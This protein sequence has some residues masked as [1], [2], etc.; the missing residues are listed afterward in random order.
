MNKLRKLYFVLPICMLAGVLIFAGPLT[1]QRVRSKTSKLKVRT[2]LIVNFCLKA[3]PLSTTPVTYIETKTWLSANAAAIKTPNVKR[4]VIKRINGRMVRILESQINQMWRSTK[5]VTTPDQSM[6]E[7]SATGQSQ[8]HLQL[9]LNTLAKIVEENAL[10]KSSS[11]IARDIKRIRKKIGKLEAEI[12]AFEK[13]IADANKAMKDEPE[14]LKIEMEAFA[15]AYAN[16]FAAKVRA[17]TELDN[18]NTELETA[19]FLKLV[20]C[21]PELNSTANH[22]VKARAVIEN[23]GEDDNDVRD[24]RK[25]LKTFQKIYS[26]VHKLAKE[27]AHE[28]I[29]DSLKL[30]QKSAASAC[31]KVELQYNTAKSSYKATK[32]AREKIARMKKQIAE[33]E[34]KLILLRKALNDLVKLAD[35][36]VP[37]AI[38]TPAIISK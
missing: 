24:M 13:N 30:K 38:G 2:T 17:K 6:I 3:D 26:T 22:C 14:I 9:Y 32:A 16:A 27:N 15:R 21:D 31:K 35:T 11:K 25:Q 19:R 8:T 28:A 29:V 33:R 1:A 20:N 10:E 12:V 37:I 4:A 7:I 5:V 18:Y 34:D 36:Y 23:P